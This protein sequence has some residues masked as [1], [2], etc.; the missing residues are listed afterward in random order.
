LG[1]GAVLGAGTGL[2]GG[3][4]PNGKENCAAAGTAHRTRTDRAAPGPRKTFVIAV[5]IM[6]PD[7]TVTVADGSAGMVTKV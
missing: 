6:E 1:A 2:G 3:G 7:P 4:A 5:P